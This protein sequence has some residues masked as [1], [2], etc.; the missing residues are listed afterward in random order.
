MQGL[1]GYQEFVR[2]RQGQAACLVSETLHPESQHACHATL[3]LSGWHLSRPAAAY[4][5][6]ARYDERM[7]FLKQH[8]AETAL[9]LMS[10][11]SVLQRHLM[12]WSMRAPNL[13][14]TL[15]LKLTQRTRVSLGLRRG[16]A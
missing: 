4:L 15:R 10:W 16:H 12:G 5:G 7:C 2:Q 1:L 9:V 8:G 6:A 13:S 3:R 11:P 14:R